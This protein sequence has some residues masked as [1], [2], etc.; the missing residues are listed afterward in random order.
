MAGSPRKRERRAAALE[1]AG[2]VPGG[3]GNHVAQ[4]G[5]RLPAWP[6]PALGVPTSPRQSAARVPAM[7]SPAE[8]PPSP[9]TA[10]PSPL[11]ATPSQAPAPP[12]AAPPAFGSTWS[13]PAGSEATAAATNTWRDFAAQRDHAS[14]VGHGLQ[15]DTLLVQQWAYV[16]LQRGVPPSACYV[17]LRRTEP[18]PMYDLIVPGDAIVA[19]LS[20]VRNPALALQEYMERNRRQPETAEYFR[21][22]IQGYRVG[23]GGHQQIEDL[24]GGDMSLS[25]RPTQPQQQPT[26]WAA[27]AMAPPG[28]APP[29]G[30]PPGYPMP[31]GYPGAP[32]YPIPPYGMPYGGAPGYGMPYGWPMMMGAPQQQPPPPPAGADPQQQAMW[33]MQM[34]LWKMQSDQQSQ[35]MTRMMDHPRSDGPDVQSGPRLRQN[36]S[37]SCAAAAVAGC[38][39]GIL[40]PDGDIR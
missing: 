16:I 13:A 36:G 39:L 25:P 11:P 34:D 30:M 28:W 18:A 20:G 32:T 35:W 5:A 23:G 10:P 17:T 27:P 33:K 8:A 4:I 12:P 38:A 3:S 1:A 29:Y 6:T 40:K 21:G 22:R 7:P 19:T 2:V 15:T 26:G 14:G 9:Q 24:G 37:G 31:Q